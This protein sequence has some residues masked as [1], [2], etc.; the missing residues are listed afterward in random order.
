[1]L[2]DVVAC[3]GFYT[4]LPVPDKTVAD[5]G[6]AQW[7][8]PVSG[9][10]VGLVGAGVCTVAMASGLP[11]L[12]ASVLALAA[13]VLATGALHED[14]LADVADGFGGGA[15]GE[16]KLEIMRDSRIGTYGVCALVIDMVLRIT[17]IAALASAG[18]W[19]VVWALLAVH[20]ASRAI[21]PVFMRN[22]PQARTSGLA[23]GVG[24][25]P[26]GSAHLALAIGIVS[27]L[28]LGITASV[29]SVV[30][31]AAWFLLLRAIALHQI[32]G[33][34]GDVIGTLQQ[35]GEIAVLLAACAI[36]S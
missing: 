18:S 4:R 5:F 25:I 27:L 19:L 7:A 10:A 22:L 17:L 9:V 16:R 11:A 20:T 1:M 30:L 13:T 21:M 36:L 31:L 2:D 12:P 32:G 15:T 3:L 6:Q 28:P 29:V 14:G 26:A 23:A 34:T 35:G 33:Q 24:S 8:A